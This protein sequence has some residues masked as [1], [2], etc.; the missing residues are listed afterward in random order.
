MS[1]VLSGGIGSLLQSPLGAALSSLTPADLSL[2][3]TSLAAQA[4]SIT[5]TSADC[6]ASGD[7]SDR[8]YR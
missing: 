8:H 2:P 3:I 1:G 4:S 7:A 6:G 5:G